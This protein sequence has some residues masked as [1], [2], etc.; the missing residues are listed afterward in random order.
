MGEK[1]GGGY[2]GELGDGAEAAFDLA[3]A[4]DDV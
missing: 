4:N 2:S 1:L 3:A